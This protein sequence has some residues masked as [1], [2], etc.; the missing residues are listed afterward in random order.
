MTDEEV[1]G[2]DEIA[3]RVVA[4]FVPIIFTARVL[5]F[6]VPTPVAWPASMLAWLLLI[7]WFPTRTK[8]SLRRW[9]MVVSFA[10]IAVL[11]VA[12]LDP[13]LL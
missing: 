9:L 1:D 8:M 2:G 4:L 3:V 5:S 7:Y 6:W 11:I 13:D 12:I 10:T